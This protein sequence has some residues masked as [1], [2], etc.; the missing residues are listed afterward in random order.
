[1]HG[2]ITHIVTQLVI[3]LAIILIA[4][5]LSGEL[6]M[7][8]LRI[9][10]VLGEL[11]A[12]VI[13][14]PHAL[15]G[16]PIFGWEAFP[17]LHEAGAS[18]VIPVSTELWSIA[19]VASIVLLFFVGLELNLKV[20]LRYAGPATAVALGGVL[21]P[22]VL[23]MVGT[24]VLGYADGYTDAQALF[25][26]A[27]M[28]A[29]SVGITARVLSDLG[30][31]DSS[32]GVT[33]I[34]AAV[35]DDVLG[36]IVLTVIVGIHAAGGV[37]ASNVLIVAIKALGFWLGLSVLGTL[38]APYIARGIGAMRV[39]G[40]SV[41]M[42]LGLAFLAAGLA[43]TFGL[44]FIIG[45][46]SMGLALSGTDLAKRLEE[47]L[48]AVYEALVPVFFV[49][50]GTL[51]DVPSM[52][53]TIVFGTVITLLAIV[54]KVVGGMAPALFTGF[55]IRGSSRIGVGMLPRGEVALIIAGIGLAEGVIGDEI[56]GVSI[57]MTV[58]TTILAPMGLVL[59]FRNRA[60]GRR[61]PRSQRG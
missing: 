1:M 33:V 49:V 4:A 19:Q 22:F 61:M 29:T 12:G 38:V 6:C 11:A 50:M 39:R 47:P 40:A 15:G 7:R 2:D 58:V 23:G 56:F 17:A 42:F 24:V 43:E 25:V 44:A 28:T 16:M 53:D 32:E 27:I 34:A 52:A 5:K 18:S 20:F 8:F 21:L 14:G 9:P 13:I 54:G 41:A 60:D 36:I 51:V 48:S 26:G 10:P 55:N 46:F 59:L 35:V 30:A 31:L 45:A 3:Q 57:L 37:S